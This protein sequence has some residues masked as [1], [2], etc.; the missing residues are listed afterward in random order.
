[1]RV[2][3]AGGSLKIRPLQHW[4]LIVVLQAL[5]CGGSSMESHP[6]R[7]LT[8][9][10]PPS[11]RA[12]EDSSTS[13][14]SARAHFE[15][16]SAPTAVI[17][18][19]DSTHADFQPLGKHY[20]LHSEPR[21]IP[22][23]VLAHAENGLPVINPARPKSLRGLSSA[24]SFADWFSLE[25][26]RERVFAW[27]FPIVSKAGTELEYANPLFFPIDNAPSFEPGFTSDEDG[28]D[29]NFHFTMEFHQRFV[30]EGD[31]I[32]SFGGDDDIWVFVDDRLVIDLGG[33]HFRDSTTVTLDSLGLVV[34]KVYRLSLYFAER[35][36]GGSS[37][38]FKSVK[39]LPECPFLIRTSN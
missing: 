3:V 4:T 16:A 8:Q 38:H 23:L 26:P 6:Q 15:C 31:E 22:G 21:V 28:K 25:H 37:L 14:Q 24:A 10:L 29:H 32:L 33:A 13:P 1:M 34:G 36:T 12:I 27:Q 18:D 20:V 2:E 39:V 9:P 5:A 35:C 11:P 17:R 7:S 30:Y 19:F